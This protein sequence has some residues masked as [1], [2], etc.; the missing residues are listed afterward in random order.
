MYQTLEKKLEK[1]IRKD[2]L[3]KI[4][5]IFLE[6]YAMA[7]IHLKNGGKFPAFVW[8][9]ALLVCYDFPSCTTRLFHPGN[10]T[11]KRQVNL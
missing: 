2:R 10:L 7:T 1:K 3:Q 9:L 8:F 11:L 6:F 4:C 5:G